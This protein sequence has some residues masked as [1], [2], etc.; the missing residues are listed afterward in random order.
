MTILPYNGG[1]HDE[2]TRS[3][4]PQPRDANPT[5]FMGKSTILSVTHDQVSTMYTASRLL[6]GGGDIHRSPGAGR[7]LSW[8]CF[9]SPTT[10]FGIE[11]KQKS[12]VCQGLGQYV[13]VLCDLN[14]AI[15][16]KEACNSFDI[17]ESVLTLSIFEV[18]CL[19]KSILYL[20]CMDSLTDIVIEVSYF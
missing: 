14:R 20:P 6:R 19:L 8:R 12:I 4:H 3:A 13:E 1:K 9:V 11:N 5:L 2:T 16:G 7:E 18:C 10:Y 15:S 17:L